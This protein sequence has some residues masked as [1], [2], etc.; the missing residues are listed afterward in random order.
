[1]ALF[2]GPKA[3]ATKAAVIAAYSLCSSTMLVVNK[4]TIHRMPVPALV[5]G[6]QLL[7]AALAVLALHAVGALKLPAPRWRV[8]Q[9]FA[10]YTTS[11]AASIYANIK[12]LE[13][14]SVGVVI[15]ARACL[16]LLVVLLERMFMGR[17]LPN[18]RSSLSLLG[19]VLCSVYYVLEDSK[20]VVNNAAGWSWLAAWW[21][22]L[23]FQMTYGKH[24][25]VALDLSEHERV[26]YTNTLS[27]P[28]ILLLGFC[29]GEHQLVHT[30]HFSR[31]T[32]TYLAMSCSIGLGISY[33]GWRLKD[34]VT[35]TTFTLVGVINKLVT[36]AFSILA[37]P[38]SSSVA[39]CVAL[40]AAILCGLLYSDA[41]LRSEAKE[42][43]SPRA[44][45]V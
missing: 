29:M 21:F 8:L 1:M 35:A 2:P 25:T 26:F 28:P 43:A 31:T 16:P 12:A 6:S 41:P 9:P 37:F 32:C 13:L 45:I 40:A 18:V 19:V 38:G 22:L 4:M 5:G 42:K 20:L 3:K 11:F 24:I 15:A 14:T 34:M 27:V 17:Q 30:I 36:I 7:F 39:G 33:T 23:A 44:L 10:I